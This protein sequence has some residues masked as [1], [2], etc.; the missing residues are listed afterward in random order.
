MLVQEIFETKPRK[1]IREFSPGEVFKYDGEWFMVIQ[2]DF[3]RIRNWDEFC[4]DNI[5]NPRN[6]D[7][8]ECE[9]TPCII[10]DTGT[11]CFLILRLHSV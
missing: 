10:L 5:H 7:C 4:A 6:M 3:D 11:F 2:V 1:T 9:L 8:N